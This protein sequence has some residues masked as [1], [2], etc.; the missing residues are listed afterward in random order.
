MFNNKTTAKN[1]NKD[2]DKDRVT[3]IVQ[4]IERLIRESESDRS[5]WNSKAELWYGFAVNDPAVVFGQN[6]LT[7]EQKR[8]P[9]APS[10]IHIPFVAE[11]VESC[12]AI[13]AG[14]DIELRYVPKVDQ[15][16]GV[17]QGTETESGLPPIDIASLVRMGNAAWEAYRNVA[18]WNEHMHL[19]AKNI[20]IF[21][22]HYI[23]PD[24]DFVK[25]FPN[26]CVTLRSYSPWQVFYTAGVR[27]NEAREYV[28]VT[29]C[30]VEELKAQFPE[31]ADEIAEL[32]YR[33]SKDKEDQDDSTPWYVKAGGAGGS[34]S[35]LTLGSY[36]IA[37]PRNT[38]RVLTRFKFDASLE[39]VS[40]E[41]DENVIQQEHAIINDMIM[42]GTPI[43]VS[44]EL[45]FDVSQYHENHRNAHL[46]LVQQIQSEAAKEVVMHV[47]D[48]FGTMMQVKRPAYST[49]ELA[50]M[51][52]VV[53]ILMTHVLW[54]EDIMRDMKPEMIGKYPRYEGGWR[55]TIVVGDEIL[56]YDGASK[57][58][59]Q[60]GIQGVPLVEFSLMGHPL[61]H[62]GDSYVAQIIP[63][64]RAING[65]V[66][67]I[68]DN[69][70][71]FGNNKW[72]TNEKIKNAIEA[73]IAYISNDPKE[74][75]VFP[76]DAIMG[77]DFGIISAAGLPPDVFSI[78]SLVINMGH[79]ASA[80][81]PS[82][83]GFQQQGVR[84]AVHSQQLASHSIA[85]TTYRLTRLKPALERLGTM[86]FKM[87]LAVPPD[88]SV[89]KPV[90]DG[91]MIEIDT[92]LLKKV[93]FT[94]EVVVNPGGTAALEDRNS[95]MLGMIQNFMNHPSAQL[96]GAMPAYFRLLAK[97]VKTSMPDLAQAFED[98]ADKMEQIELQRQQ[99]AMM[100]AASQ[101]VPGAPGVAGAPGIPSAPAALPMGAG[102]I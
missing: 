73:G 96:P 102:G 81:S 29:W 89:I 98:M 53:E 54:H 37:A 13:L 61:H 64:N 3:R 23:A 5:S 76:D 25:C 44:G 93:D 9:A 8:N 67:A 16:V 32:V 26:P 30:N 95:I 60:F 33:K 52:Q 19:M 85:Q 40:T 94:I 55:Q 99:M 34:S 87:M 72:W 80:V 35:T 36:S 97:G 18:G 39:T 100:A 21:D 38:L 101:G 50:R 56:V 31:Y 27:F 28:I 70:R 88:D 14:G 66:N 20:A 74:P 15:D 48:E 10:Q 69:I 11:K 17:A 43:D 77:K 91:R 45:K 59:T 49:A 83:Q 47:P 82:V 71:L 22:R 86:M 42:G 12:V 6:A 68:I 84:S 46:L 24:I 63:H 4:S 2:K 62:W 92:E 51:A 90:I 75:D 78:L 57:F 79:S 41:A 7:D 58:Y 1:R 65:L